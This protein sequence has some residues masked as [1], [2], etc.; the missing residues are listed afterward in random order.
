MMH[1][2]AI[3]FAGKLSRNLVV[4]PLVLVILINNSLGE[5]R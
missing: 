2:R 1:S 5:R 4:L 3:I